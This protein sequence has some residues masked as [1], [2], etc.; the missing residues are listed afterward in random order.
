[1]A[2]VCLNDAGEDEC[3]GGTELMGADCLVYWVKCDDKDPWEEETLDDFLED[4]S[5]LDWYGWW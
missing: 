1:M 2:H 4:D 5:W 3:D